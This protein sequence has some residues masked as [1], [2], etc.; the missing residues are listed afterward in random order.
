MVHHFTRVQT[1]SMC[2]KSESQ[3][4]LWTL[5]DDVLVR[6]QQWLT[7]ESHWCK[8]LM[9]QWRAQSG[10]GS[11]MCEFSVLPAQC[12]CEPETAEM[13]FIN[14]TTKRHG[15]LNALLA[16]L[17]YGGA[18]QNGK[19]CLSASTTLPVYRE[20]STHSR[21]PDWSSPAGTRPFGAPPSTSS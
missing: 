9:G 7:D 3:H 18:P 13:K 15:C 12:F 6:V 17:T 11:S 10:R 16:F 21:K 2:T 4:K 5:G 1:H 20:G 8:L 19:G 14:V